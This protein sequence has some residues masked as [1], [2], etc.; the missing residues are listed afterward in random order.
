MAGGRWSAAGG[1]WWP[2]VAGGRWPVVSAA[3]WWV[4][5]GGGRWPVAGGVGGSVVHH[6]RRAKLFAGDT[7]KLG[8]RVDGRK[9]LVPRSCVLLT[10]CVLPI[11]KEELV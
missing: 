4:V 5:A 1:G 9:L 11:T 3:R 10:Q 2:A 7:G 6:R 8:I